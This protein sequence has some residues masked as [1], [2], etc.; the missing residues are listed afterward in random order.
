MTIEVRRFQK[1]DYERVAEM[2]M[3][4]FRRPMRPDAW[5]RGE[6]HLLVEDGRIQAT[7]L[8]EPMGQVFGGRAVPSTAVSGVVVDPLARG[9]GLSTLLLRETFVELRREG[10][11][12]STLFPSLVGA[13]RQAGYEFAGARVEYET[14]IDRLPTSGNL[15]GVEPWAD[16][17]LDEIISCYRHA[18]QLSNGLF[19]RTPTWWRERVFEPVDGQPFYRYLVRRDGCVKGYLLYTQQPLSGNHGLDFSVVARDLFWLDGEAALALLAVVAQH[20]PLGSDFRWCGPVNEP[21][22]MYLGHLPPTVYDALPMMLRLIN[23]PAALEARGYAPA[24]NTCVSFAVTD[25]LLPENSG[26]LRI[27]VRDGR[28]IVEPVAKAQASVDVG[29]L[30]ALYSGWLRASDAARLGNLVGASAA[31]IALLD[32]LFAGPAAWMPDWI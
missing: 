4:A 16:S 21:L 27:A 6:G 2:R 14:R 12:L 31:E 11:A 3:E 17:N 15:P 22:A 19:D 8:A 24:L 10:V 5:L 1:G 20:R 13:Y 28:A 23:V 18:A 25:S 30:A 26:A 29:T 32:L 7:V 9:R